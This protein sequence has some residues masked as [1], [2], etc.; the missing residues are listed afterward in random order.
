M[1][2]L[3]QHPPPARTDREYP[4]RRGRGTLLCP[5]RGAIL[6]RLTQTKWPPRNPARFNHPVQDS[7]SS[8]RGLQGVHSARG[9][10]CP[11]TRTALSIRHL[12]PHPVRRPAPF[13]V[14]G[15]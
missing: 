2:E 15:V 4:S 11:S 3:V 14:S 1:G 10:A 6:G 13:L 12:T 8:S 7:A 9:L 5:G